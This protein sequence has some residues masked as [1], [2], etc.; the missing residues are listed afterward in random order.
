MRIVVTGGAGFIGSCFLWKLNQKGISDIIV[1]DHLGNSE[2]WKN[3][4]G[5]QFEDYLEKEPFLEQL[6]AGRFGNTIDAVVHMGACSSTTETDASYLMQNNYRY[7]KKLAQ[8][9]LA[10]EKRFIYASSAATYGMGEHGYVDVDK[11]SPLLKPLN[12]YGYSKHAFDLWLLKNGFQ[13]RCA[14]IKFFNVYGPN[15]YH[16]E[17]MRSMVLK[18]Y[19]QIKET[20][21]IKLFRS[22]RDDYEHGEQKRDFVYIKDAVAAMDYLLDSPEIN[23]IFNL[24]TGIAATWNQLAQAIFQ[25][26]N[27]S[28]QIEYVDM[29]WVLREKY[30]YFTQADMTK[31]KETGY[32]TSPTPLADAVSEYVTLLEQGAFL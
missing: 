26:L 28:E 21:K 1:V 3:L 5:K 29:P 22:H 15:E 25:A 18:G 30:Q 10:L 20:G 6:T 4:V 23:G 24:G 14:G 13:S 11:T 2:K 12:M 31:L 8:W 27:L 7:T 16:K 9:A 19:E 32:D 17:D